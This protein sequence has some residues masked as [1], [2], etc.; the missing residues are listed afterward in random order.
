MKITI[1]DVLSLNFL[2]RRETLII[3]GSINSDTNAL[4][5]ALGMKAEREGVSVM[6]VNA[7]TL[8]EEIEGQKGGL[9]AARLIAVAKP[10][11]LIVENLGTKRIAPMQAK[12]LAQI[13]TER[14]NRAST[15]FTSPYPLCAWTNRLGT[16]REIKSLF[17]ILSANAGQVVIGTKGHGVRKTKPAPAENRC[18][19]VTK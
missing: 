7:G 10:K 11:L 19:L 18:R 1:R 4:A 16:S 15:V 5:R 17:N 3:S 2:H 8:D 12:A 14:V 13:V 9:S 6:T